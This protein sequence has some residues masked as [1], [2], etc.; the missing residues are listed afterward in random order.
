MCLARQELL[1]GPELQTAL[2]EIG[3]EIDNI[4]A[5]WNWAGEQGEWEAIEQALDGLYYFYEIR[6]RYQDGEELFAT[7]IAQLE[8]AASGD[9]LA[10]HSLLRR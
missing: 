2:E 6:S 3:A 8:Q 1:N 10:G 7:T 9:R 4:R 5:A